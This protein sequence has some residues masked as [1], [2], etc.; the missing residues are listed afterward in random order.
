MLTYA[1]Q[2]DTLIR[3]LVDTLASYENDHSDALCPIQREADRSFNGDHTLVA[4]TTTAETREFKKSVD[5]QFQAVVAILTL[6][7]THSMGDSTSTPSTTFPHALAAAPASR[8]L[9]GP[10]AAPYTSSSSQHPPAIPTPP[11]CRQL[12]HECSTRAPQAIPILGLRIPNLPQGPE[13]WRVAVKQWHEVDET[14]GKSLKEWPTEWFTGAMR[15]VFAV[16]RTA[17][18]I[19]A[20]EYDR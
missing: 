5:A 20:V 11:V 17:R 3:Y 9:S 18:Q 16:K 10:P 19:I 4:P 6:F 13:A 14:T 8:V 2:A 15:S 1:R 7:L 12:E